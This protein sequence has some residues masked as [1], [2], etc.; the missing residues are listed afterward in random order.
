LLE[1]PQPA[2]VSAR[3]TAPVSADVGTFPALPTRRRVTTR[4]KGARV[5]AGPFASDVASYL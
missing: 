1:E 5:T 4:R 3:A 2:S